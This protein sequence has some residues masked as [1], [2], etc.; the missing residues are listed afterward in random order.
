M[1]THR[2]RGPDGLAYDVPQHVLLQRGKWR[3]V[4]PMRWRPGPVSEFLCQGRFTQDAFKRAIELNQFWHEAFLERRGAGLASPLKHTLEW[5]AGEFQKTVEYRLMKPRTREDVDWAFRLLTKEG[6]PWRRAKVQS[7]DRAACKALFQTMHDSVGHRQALK[8]LTWLRRLMTY[9]MDLRL[10]TVNPASRLDLPHPKPRQ[11]VWT[12]LELRAACRAAV[13]M[14]RP[15]IALALLIAY[16]SAQRPGDVLA[17]QWPQFDGE[18]IA[19][20]QQKTGKV[21]WTPLKAPARY[22]LRHTPRLEAGAIIVN[23]RSGKPYTRLQWSRAFREVLEAAGINRDLRLAD[24]RRTAGSEILAGGGKA[25]PLGGWAI[26]SPILG[27][28]Q[29]PSKEAARASQASRRRIE[30]LLPQQ[31]GTEP[32]KRANAKGKRPRGQ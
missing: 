8:V 27:T 17:C 7:I 2:L 9:A 30:H 20:L 13:R 29:V 22:L 5:L 16:D 25:E 21:A 26:N 31:Q 3:W 14:G 1:K 15:S 4:P 19:W 32:G 24:T 10:I 18:G 6:S 28:Y 23:E 11:I 12:W